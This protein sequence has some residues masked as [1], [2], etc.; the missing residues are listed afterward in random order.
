MKTE[1][2]TNPETPNTPQTL[3]DYIGAVNAKITWAASIAA[4]MDAQII[5]M[6]EVMSS[7]DLPPRWPGAFIAK[8][9]KGLKMGVFNTTLNPDWHAKWLW[10]VEIRCNVSTLLQALLEMYKKALSEIEG[11]LTQELRLDYSEIPEVQP[12]KIQ[13]PY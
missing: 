2:N 4:N 13:T 9:P 8:A 6:D 1:H 10:Q 7:G 12:P 11:L 3:S 5:E